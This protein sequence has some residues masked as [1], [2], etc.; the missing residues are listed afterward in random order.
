MFNLCRLESAFAILAP[1]RY[2][3]PEPP[4][5]REQHPNGPIYSSGEFWSES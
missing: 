5:R 3:R 1:P 4:F 2:A